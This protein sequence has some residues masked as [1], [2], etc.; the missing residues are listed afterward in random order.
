[1]SRQLIKSIIFEYIIPLCAITLVKLG[2]TLAA[3]SNDQKGIDGIGNV[4]GIVI[5]MRVAIAVL[6][7]IFLVINP[8]RILVIY[9]QELAALA[10]ALKKA[11]CIVLILIPVLVSIPL[12]F[13]VPISN[14]LYDRK[15]GTGKGA[16]K[17]AEENYRLPGEFRDELV[18]RGLYYNGDAA[19]VRRDLNSRFA[20]YIS[21]KFEEY[22]YAEGTIMPLTD[23]TFYD[24][25][26][27]NVILD[28]DSDTTGY[29]AYIYNAV[30][31]QKD[32]NDALKYYPFARYDDKG[33]LIGNDYPFFKDYYIEC[34]IM[35]VDGDIY[36][37][38]GVSES[39]DIGKL[40]DTF[41]RPFYLILAEK[42][43][44]TTFVDGK[45]YPYGAIGNEGSSFEMHPNTTEHPYT[46]NSPA[47]YPVRKVDRVDAETINKVAAE[48]QNGILKETVEYHFEKVSASEKEEYAAAEKNEAAGTDDNDPGVC[49]YVFYAYG[50]EEEPIEGV[51]INICNNDKCI[52]ITTDADGSAVF[53]GEP[54]EYHVQVARAPKGWQTVGGNE[55]YT[56]LRSQEFVVL[57]KKTETGQ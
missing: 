12:I 9:R 5:I 55:F 57:F 29:P 23:E 49:E 7:V 34:K 45:Y 10:P 19:T 28:P 26:D 16:Y 32:K 47:N 8:I 43:D 38:I 24:T 52:P 53:T 48:L 3:N 1:M 56:G 46:S 22:Y 50:P 6:A 17:A 37:V 36:A 30:L 14:Y 39:Y 18:S 2:A 51:I 15:Y 54:E 41:E 13:E 20:G 11:G 33:W 35:Y 27:H 4:L 42:D 21:T 44:I 25:P 31:V 40:Y